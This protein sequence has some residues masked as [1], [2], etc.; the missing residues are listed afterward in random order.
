MMKLSIIYIN[1][2]A[3]MTVHKRS[4]VLCVFSAAQILIE[5]DSL[6]WPVQVS[7]PPTNNIDRMKESGMHMTIDAH[8]PIS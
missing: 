8:P 3:A 6:L 1:D 2:T 5:K 7:T 4:A